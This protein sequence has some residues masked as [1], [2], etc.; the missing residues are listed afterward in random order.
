MKYSILSKMKLNLKALSAF[1]LITLSSTIALAQDPNALP[2]EPKPL[3]IDFWFYTL[4]LIAAVLVFAVINKTVKALELTQ[5]LNGKDVGNKW[6]K[7]NGVIFLIFG[8]GFFSAIFWEFNTHGRQLLPEAASIHGAQTDYL[9]NITLIFTVVVF[10]L[11]HILL[12]FFAFKYK[13]SGKRKAFFYSHNDKL[14]VYWTLIPAIVLAV[15]VF[16]GWKTWT[17]ITTPAPQEALQLDVTGKQFA[18]IVRYPGTDKV[19]GTKAFKLVNDVN[20]TGVNYNDKNATDDFFTREI[21]L[22]VNR[23]VKFNFGARD[24]LHSAYMPHFRA[25]MNCVPGMPTTFWFTPTITTD[26]MRVKTNDPKFDYLLLCAKICGT[27]HYNMQVKIV[28]VDDAAYATWLATQKPYYTEE[29]AK[30]ITEA[31]VA[32]MKAEEERKLALN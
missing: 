15:L 24:V 18:W 2:T 32:R 27:A 19:L 31:E 11:T 4:L 28:V 3:S 16:S 7:I 21:Y 6:N 25:Q 26:E 1:A 30:Q 29:T 23:P 20:E 22:P 17:N 9:F 13:G 5:T 14:E 8:L 10:V 12:F